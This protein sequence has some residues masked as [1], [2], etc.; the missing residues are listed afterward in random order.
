MKF[1]L[2]SVEN[3]ETHIKLLLQ[4]SKSQEIYENFKNNFFR[5]M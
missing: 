1:A 4:N 2:R 3:N 5:V